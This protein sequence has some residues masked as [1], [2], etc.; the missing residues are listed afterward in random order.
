MESNGRVLGLIGYGQVGSRVA[1]RALAFDMKV[2]VYDPYIEDRIL[3]EDGCISASLDE[4]LSESDFVSIHTKLSDETYH[5]INE[6]TLAKMKP[7]AVL[8]NTAR[9]SIVDEKALY[10]ALKNGIIT[11]AAIDVF[12]DDPI[13]PD[14]LLISLNNITI[15][16]HTAGRSPFTE[17]RGYQQI[18]LQVARFLRGEEIQPQHISN[19]P[20]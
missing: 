8:I 14:N 17:I 11:S 1:K 7:T 5:M 10:N 19:L 12:E 9:G 13:K 18:A 2:I 15:T 20:N 3:L 4:V 16:P 6:K